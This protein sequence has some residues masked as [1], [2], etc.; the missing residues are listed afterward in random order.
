MSGSASLHIM[1]RLPTELVS[2]VI[3]RL[4]LPDAKSLSR[5][6][7]EWR[8]L[9]LPRVFRQMR[10]PWGCKTSPSPKILSVCRRFV[11]HMNSFGFTASDSPE[12]LDWL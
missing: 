10:L 2:L 1:Q 7:K 3:E 12:Y 8:E 11:F 6:D 5:V 4:P 9:S